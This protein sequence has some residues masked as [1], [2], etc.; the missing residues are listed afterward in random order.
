MLVL[1]RHLEQFGRPVALYSD[2]HSIFRI[3]QE[4]PANGNTRTQFGR[5]MESLE[6]EGI[7]ARTP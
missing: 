2:R 4:D 1:R 6:I 3:N 7:H 5:A